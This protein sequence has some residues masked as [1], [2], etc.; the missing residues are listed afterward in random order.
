MNG[1]RPLHKAVVQVVEQRRNRQDHGNGVGHVLRVVSH[2]DNKLQFTGLC[3]IPG[4]SA[5]LEWHVLL[6]Q[7]RCRPGA[8]LFE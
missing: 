4:A 1:G 3:L 2:Q 6:A 7:S 5:S 8:G